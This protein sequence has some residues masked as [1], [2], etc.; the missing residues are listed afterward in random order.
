MISA[1]IP[2]AVMSDFDATAAALYPSQCVML[3]TIPSGQ[4]GSCRRPD[5]MGTGGYPR[6][7]RDWRAQART[8]ANSRR[9]DRT[10]SITCDFS[11]IKSSD[12]LTSSSV[13]STAMAIGR[14]ARKLLGLCR[15][16]CILDSRI[17]Y[18]DIV[19]PSFYSFF[20][21]RFWRIA[22]ASILPMVVSGSA[23]MH[24]TTSGSLWAAIPSESKNSRSCV[25]TGGVPDETM[26]AQIR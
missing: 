20:R 9:R 21:P 26:T 17:F 8:V 5:K 11:S 24:S 4:I 22:L 2:I 7:P 15:V 16:S 1:S 14:I 13:S 23:G 19:E 12:S 6:C 18:W 25:R 3:L 10:A